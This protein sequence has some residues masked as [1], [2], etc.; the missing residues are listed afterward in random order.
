[1]RKI[2]RNK[3]VSLLIV[4]A[5]VF[6][7]V[8]P[9]AAYG[10][11]STPKQGKVTITLENEGADE[12][13]LPTIRYKDKDDWHD[14]TE[15][16]EYQPPETELERIMLNYDA[17]YCSIRSV[18]I[19]TESGKCFTVTPETVKDKDFAISGDNFKGNISYLQIR[20]GISSEI[21]LWGKTLEEDVEIIFTIEPSL[22]YA[23]ANFGEKLDNYVEDYSVY[24]EEQQRQITEIIEWAKS[25]IKRAN[26]KEAVNG[27]IQLAQAQIDSVNRSLTKPQRKMQLQRKTL[28]RRQKNRNC[29]QAL[30]RP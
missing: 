28:Q 3:I 1:M 2:K 23:K 13:H 7:L 21:E 25:E 29:R 20:Q 5:M 16:F 30:R 17:E 15:P 10:E 9:S 4:F 12:N 6:T 14:Y 24:T 8:I 18:T 26:S 22:A 11:E 19:K 27:I